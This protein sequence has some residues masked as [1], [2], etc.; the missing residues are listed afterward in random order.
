MEA[1]VKFCK[2]I[3]E[4]FAGEID[5]NKFLKIINI[6]YTIFSKNLYGFPVFYKF[7]ATAY[8]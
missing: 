7:F 6:F 3:T 1:R 2:T 4:M 8:S 5:E